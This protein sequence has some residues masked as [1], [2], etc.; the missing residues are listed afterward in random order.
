MK[1][2][3]INS[4]VYKQAIQELFPEWYKCLMH[5]RNRDIKYFIKK[6]INFYPFQDLFLSGITD[7][8]SCSSYIPSINFRMIEYQFRDINKSTYKI[9]LTIV[10]S[11]H[12]INHVN[13]CIIFFKGNDKN[14]INTPERKGKIYDK[15]KEGG[16]NLEC[17]LFGE[18]INS[19]NLLQCLYI[20]NEENYKQDLLKFRENFKN[21]R[22]IVASTDGETKFI[23]IKKGV[24][25]K[26]YKES[27]LEI[28]NIVKSIKYN[29]IFIPTMNIGKSNKNKKNV[30]YIPKR[31]C[32]LIGGGSL[33]DFP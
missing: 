14:L 2:V 15:R 32:G 24:F 18:I 29:E 11:I 7:K 20:M 21:I 17:L 27:I 33:K 6:R 5:N 16:E 30:N 8:L 28:K 23:K 22:N 9:G 12:E 3:N 10:N 26:F 31:K 13:Q 1:L 25:K 4:K 19:V